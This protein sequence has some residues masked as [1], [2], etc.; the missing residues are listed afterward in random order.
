M[1]GVSRGVDP[2]VKLGDDNEKGAKDDEGKKSASVK[3]FCYIRYTYKIGIYRCY[4]IRYPCIKIQSKKMQ[5]LFLWFFILFVGNFAQ[6]NFLCPYRCDAQKGSL[7][8]KLMLTEPD[9]NVPDCIIDC[10]LNK[11]PPY[12]CAFLS[13]LSLGGIP[14]NKI[15][16]L[17]KKIMAVSK[18]N[19]APL[20]AENNKLYTLLRNFDTKGC[21]QHIKLMSLELNTKTAKEIH[22]K[23]EALLEQFKIVFETK[24][25][26]F[27]T[28]PPTEKS[29]HTFF[30]LPNTK[31]LFDWCQNYCTVQKT[32]KTFRSMEKFV[33]HNAMLNVSDLRDKIKNKEMFSHSKNKYLTRSYKCLSECPFEKTSDYICYLLDTIDVKNDRTEVSRKILDLIAQ[34]ILKSSTADKSAGLRLEEYLNNPVHEKRCLDTLRKYYYR[35]RNYTASMKYLKSIYGGIEK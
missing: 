33:K 21:V 14:S 24:Y 25:A 22:E 26:K 34:M 15:R 35:G 5:K 11:I 4:F 20:S 13:E 12:Y 31:N 10:S 16:S 1:F 8:G 18:T 32:P 17:A 9:D 30:D 6:A 28:Y 23:L 27:N 29:R 19:E 7:D 3:E 2:P